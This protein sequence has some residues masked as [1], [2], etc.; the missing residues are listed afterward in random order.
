MKHWLEV[1][2]TAILITMVASGF[3]FL[4]ALAIKWLVNL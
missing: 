1:I 2:A 3:W 4:I